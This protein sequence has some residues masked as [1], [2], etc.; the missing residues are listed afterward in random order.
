MTF[1]SSSSG[2]GLAPGAVLALA[3]LLGGC[4][5]PGNAA[6]P[7]PAVAGAEAR[8]LRIAL[9][10]PQNLSGKAV[11]LREIEEGVELSLRSRGLDVM[12]GDAVR[13]ALAAHR[14]RY[15]MGLDREA[16]RAMRDDLGVDAVLVTSVLLH[17]PVFPPRLAIDLRLVSTADTPAILWEDAFTGSGVDSPGLF[18]LTI[19]RTMEEMRPAAL[20]QLGDSL[21]ARL[22]GKGSPVPRCSKI[23]PRVIHRSRTLDG[24]RKRT[25]AMLPFVNQT[26]RRDAADAVALEVIRELIATGRFQVVEPGLV[27]NELLTNRIVVE[28]GASLDMARVV[29]TDL[30]ADVLMAGYV[31]EYEDLP[32]LSGPPRIELTVY[33]I[34]GKSGEVVW[35]SNSRSRGDD[36]VFFFGLGRVS[37][38]AELA[39]G[40]GRGIAERMAGDPGAAPVET[41]D[42]RAKGA[43]DAPADAGRGSESP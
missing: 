25:L 41:V 16:A 23:K 27:R 12:A 10:P 13:R 22:A 2:R 30:K 3:C 34:D 9:L 11:S 38:A 36:G 14:I 8:R 1:S 33:A 37:T 20:N 4:G 19:V 29:G 15:T 21:V 40:L 17:D 24:P 32:G 26:E 6:V 31:R 18:G 42:P 5:G 7:D 28:G 35:W 39:C 43:P